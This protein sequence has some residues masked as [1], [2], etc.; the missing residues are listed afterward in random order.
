MG[1]SRTMQFT[2]RILALAT[3]SLVSVDA[4]K[5]F[6]GTIELDVE[7]NDTIQNVKTRFQDKTRIPTEQQKLFFGVEDFNG[8]TRARELDDDRTL[9]HYNINKGDCICFQLNLREQKKTNN[10]TI[11]AA[12][13][14]ANP[15]MS[16]TVNDANPPAR[17]RLTNQRLIDRFIRESLRCQTS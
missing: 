12:V 14:P 5:I 1:P 10:T 11:A 6:V 16:C 4:M 8:G 15:T 7:P 9:S 2:K 13:A 3:I 17:R